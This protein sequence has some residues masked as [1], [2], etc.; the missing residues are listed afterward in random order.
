MKTSN[1]PLNTVKETPSDAELISH[2]LM[3]KAGLIRKLASGLYT[4]LPMGLLVLRKIENIIRNEMNNAAAL[5]IL[6]PTLQ[7]AELWQESKRWDFYGPE[8]LRIKD[9][10][11]RDFCYGPTHEEVVTDLIRKEIKSYKQLPITYYQI[12]TKFRDEIRPRFGIMRAREFLM[13]DAYSFHIDDK[14]L[15]ETYENMFQTYCKIFDQIGL[16]YRAVKA[17]NGSIGGQLSHEFHVI[18]DS[19]EDAIAYSD[20]GDYA[21]NIE[22]ATSLKPAPAKPGHQLIKLIDTLN[23][24][25]IADISTFLKIKP[26]QCLKTLLV[27]GNDDKIIA[28]LLRGD[29]ELNYIKAEKIES[30]KKPLTFVNESMIIEKLGCHAGSIGP[31]NLSFEILADH[32]VIAMTDFVC[33]AN[34]DHK[35]FKGVNW[36]NDLAIPETTHDL[37]NVVE[38]DPSPDQNGRLKIARGIEVGHIFQLGDKYTRSMNANVLN[39]K[40][41]SVVMTM[42]CYGI[43]VSRLVSA[44]IEQNHDDKGIIWPDSI[45][46]FQIALLPMNLH[47]SE[48][49]RNFV[50]QLYDE[51]MTAGYQVLLDDRKVRP[52]FMFADME[53]IGIP[54]RLIIG[55]KGLDSATIEY[56]HRI[57]KESTHIKIESLMAFLSEKSNVHERG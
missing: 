5:E 40:G 28:L 9:R 45:S 56:K 27:E 11:Q 30:I 34:Q 23:Q 15:I 17:D 2:Q 31:I 20:I 38:G 12:Q 52:G 3:I 24:K 51:L 48:R 54:H 6:M 46:P 32:A 35:H 29:H 14:S 33:G 49:L 22:F 25:S 42:G 26:E 39:D 10:H 18:A 8:L 16:N 19:G 57:D 7:P 55:D 47:K 36:G 1:F 44:C 50:D 43:G 53:L 4:W 37:R 21:A 41:K 13:K